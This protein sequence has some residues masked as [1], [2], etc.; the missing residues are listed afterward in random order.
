VAEP[1]DKPAA[2]R[3]WLGIVLR[4]SHLAAVTMLGAELL[5]AP[6]PRRPAAAVVL[7]SGV[8]LLII[9]IMDARM[10]FNE[11]AGFVALSK[12]A[13]V[14]WMVLDG[15]HALPVFWVVLFVSALVSH[16]PRRVRHWRP[17]RASS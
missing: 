14:T 3:R 12:L 13:A 8:A 6:L 1:S 17:G 9:E 2:W 10:R 16:A 15:E 4:A 11:L 5:G 7:A